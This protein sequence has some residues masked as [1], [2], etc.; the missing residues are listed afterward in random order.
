[1]L[2]VVLLVR[3]RILGIVICHCGSPK[4]VGIAPAIERG[5]HAY[6]LDCGEVT[7]SRYPT[8]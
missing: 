5:R 4:P 1:L 6:P 8:A 3:T 7:F 2:I